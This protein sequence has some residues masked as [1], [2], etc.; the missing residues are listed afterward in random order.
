M[1]DL[2]ACFLSHCVAYLLQKFWGGI[3]KLNV[4]IMVIVFVL[5]C[6]MHEDKRNIRDSKT[7]SFYYMFPKFSS[8]IM[9]D[10]FLMKSFCII[11]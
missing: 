10:F 1:F 11:T 3:A 6:R 5:D 9:Y 2:K 7:N 8:I 4:Y